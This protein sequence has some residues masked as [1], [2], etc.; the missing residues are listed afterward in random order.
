VDF[1]VAS[2]G[3]Q[4]F[5]YMESQDTKIIAGKHGANFWNED[6][7]EFYVNLSKNLLAK[8]YGKD[9]AQVN[10]NATNIG[11]TALTL[12]KWTV[13]TGTSISILAIH[14]NTRIAFWRML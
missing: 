3:K 2:D 11:K 7:M 8:S 4:L 9:I 10:I 5:V 13:I 14:L 1:A 6:S 12:T